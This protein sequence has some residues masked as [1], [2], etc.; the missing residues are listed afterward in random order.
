[1][2]RIGGRLQEVVFDCIRR[3]AT[4]SRM[5]SFSSCFSFIYPVLFFLGETTLY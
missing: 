3:Y 4:F 1:M 5:L 2:F